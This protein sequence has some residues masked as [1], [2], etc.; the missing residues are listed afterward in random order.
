MNDQLNSKNWKRK[1]ITIRRS[2]DRGHF[3]HGWLDTYHTF[4]FA[5]YHD[6]RH[7]GFRVLR[8]INEDR[9]QQGEGFP[10][11]SH[12]NMEIITYVLEGALEHKDSMGHS[13]V[14]RP[15]DVQR[16]SAGTG[17]THSEYNHSRTE[18]VHLLQIWIIPDRQSLEPAYEQTYFSDEDK[19]GKLCL[20]ASREGRD[21]SLTVHQDLDLYVSILEQREKVIHSILPDR[22]IWVQVTRGELE[23]EGRT[24]KAGDGASIIDEKEVTLCGLGKC[25]VILFDLP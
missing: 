6:P 1:M 25:E 15:G 12:D 7:M 17:I 18:P 11:H 20:V 8:V 22:H 23:I 24:L 2:E 9:V 16:M 10:T 21:G 14:I 3:N 19:R 13:T 4:S 5:A